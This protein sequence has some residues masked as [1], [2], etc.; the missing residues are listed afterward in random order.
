MATIH[1]ASFIRCNV[2]EGAYVTDQG[3][4]EGI[5]NETI[6]KKREINSDVKILA[7]IHVKHASPLGDFSMEDAA[8]NALYRGNADGIIVSGKETGQLISVPKLKQFVEKTSIKPILGSGL[9]IK[10]LKDVK[11]Y[12]SGAIVGSSI[13]ET[14]ISSPVDLEKAK[15][16]VTAWKSKDF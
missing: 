4:I 11:Q 5:A 1:Q 6:L 15:A 8:K 9:T 13:K 7:D 3:I 10:N 14:K 16:L 2:W 12:I